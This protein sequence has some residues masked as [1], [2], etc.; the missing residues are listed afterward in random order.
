[1]F[2]P[3]PNFRVK[4]WGVSPRLLA[5]SGDEFLG[6]FLTI[7]LRFSANKSSSMSCVASNPGRLKY[8][9]RPG[10]EAMSCA[11]YH[12]GMTGI[13]PAQLSAASLVH[14]ACL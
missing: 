10:L 2:L 14:C 4:T 8:V 13:P 11:V 6:L 3:Q 9:N 12:L 5:V 1:M 7:A